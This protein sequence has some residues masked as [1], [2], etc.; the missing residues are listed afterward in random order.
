[1]NSSRKIAILGAGMAGLSCAH[2]L[3]SAG[4][5]AVIFEKSGRIGGRMSTRVTEN[6]F[7]FDHGAQFFRAKGDAFAEFVSELEGEGSAKPW[8]A[9]A[10]SDPVNPSKPMMVGNG[11]MNELLVKLSKDLDIRFKT[12]VETIKQTSDGYELNFHGSN[13]IEQFDVVI[14]TVPVEQVRS[15]FEEQTDFLKQCSGISL[16]PCWA[17]LIG[18]DEKVECGFD[19]WRHVNADIGWIARN[20]SKPG[21]DG[22][23]DCWVVHA[24]PQWSLDNL[25]REKEDVAGD[26]LAMFESVI[27]APMLKVGYVN[28]HRWRYAQTPEP[29]GKPYLVN[30]NHSVF[31]GGDWCLGARVEA[32]FDSGTA[33]ADT[34]LR[35]G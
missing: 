7:A 9:K 16:Q 33:I 24:S 15:L 17:G 11:A 31:V 13:M 19:T 30:E 12:R 28:A 23:K 2:R 25:E 21:R 14:S 29:L 22:S 35:R 34:I 10:K 6:G 27:G 3:R 1:M 18:L 32:A 26:L 8:H 4:V 20:S 5:E